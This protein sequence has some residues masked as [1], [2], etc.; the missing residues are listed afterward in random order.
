VSSRSESGL[1]RPDA[2]I[3]RIAADAGSADTLG[4]FPGLEIAMRAT[5]RGYSFGPPPFGRN[6]HYFVHDDRVFVGTAE[7]NAVRVYDVEG[8]LL[9]II[10]GPDADLTITADLVDSYHE[11]LLEVSRERGFDPDVVAAG[12]KDEVLPPARTAYS[13][14]LV[15]DRGCLWLAE[16][17]SPFMAPAKWTVFGPD[18]TMLGDVAMPAGFRIQDVRGG[19]VVGTT[20]DEFDIQYVHIYA[21]EGR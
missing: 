21:L 4:I 2:P 14:L 6:L 20:V 8:R 12:F 5:D 9:R 16:G 10:R 3:F 13:Q 19:R 7:R 1:F 17:V 11:S 15:D 18:G